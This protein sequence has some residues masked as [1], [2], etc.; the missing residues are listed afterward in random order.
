KPGVYEIDVEGYFKAEKTSNYNLSVKFFGIST[1]SNPEFI[2]GKNYF[3]VV[4][5]FNTASA[6]S[7]SGKIQGYE[8]THNVELKGDQEIKMPFNFNAGESTKEFTIK[9]RKNDHC[10]L[11]DFAML[12]LN[13][14]GRVVNSEALSYSKGSISIDNDGNE[15]PETFTLHL[16]PGFVH[17]SNEMKFEIIEK[18]EFSNQDAISVKYAGKT[19]VTLFPNS[20]AEIECTINELTQQTAEGSKVYGKI[21]FES[22]ANKKVE[23][24]MPFYFSSQ[25]EE[26]QD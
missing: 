18:T 17:M 9:L 7:L 2:T 10:K 4:N 12:I 8:L 19:G 24:E 13:S 21:Y 23:F 16:V 20:P 5:S 15:E 26:E 14:E 11:T 3:E 25:V 6:Y 22:N 1:T